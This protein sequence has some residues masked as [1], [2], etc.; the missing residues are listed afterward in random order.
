[1]CEDCCN[2]YDQITSLSLAVRVS[3]VMQGGGFDVV[4]GNPPW[5]EKPPQEQEFLPTVPRD[6]KCPE[7]GCT[8]QADQRA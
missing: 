1:M 7:Q 8:R 6:R 4:L 2:C 3:Y 5:E